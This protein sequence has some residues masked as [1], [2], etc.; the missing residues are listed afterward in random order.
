M[1]FHGEETA[2]QAQAGMFDVTQKLHVKIHIIYFS[3]EKCRLS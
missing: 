2:N 1:I 3:P